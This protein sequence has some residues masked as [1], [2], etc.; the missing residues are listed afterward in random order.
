MKLLKGGNPMEPDKKI[1]NEED[2]CC[3]DDCGCECDEEMSADELS[4][5]NNI[6]INA[7]IELLINKKLITREEFEKTLDEMQNSDSE[8]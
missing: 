6:L 5:T 2:N 1:Q 8:E 7:V 4:E 3:C